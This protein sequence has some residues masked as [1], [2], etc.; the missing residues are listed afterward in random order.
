MQGSQTF[1]ILLLL[2][3]C[4]F[5]V[6]CTASPTLPPTPVRIEV[7][8]PVEVTRLVT[9][10]VTQQIVTAATP[11]PAVPCAALQPGDGAIVTIGAIIPLSSPGAILAGFAMQAAL[12]IAVSELN[13]QGGIEGTPV[14]LVTYDSAGSPERSAQFA[15]RLILLDCAVAIVGLYHNGEALAVADVAHRYAIPVIVTAATS[16]DITQ[17]GYAEIFRIAP[18]N[19]MLAQMPAL[20]LKDV[21]DYNRD[22]VIVATL[23]ADA[24][25]NSST[26][27]E[28]TQATMIQA[29]IETEVLRVDLPSTNFSSVVARLV[30]REHLPD[31]IFIYI[32]GEPALL[33]QA[34]L[35]AAGIGPQ[36]STLFVQNHAGLNSTQFWSEVPGGTGTIVTRIGA[37]PSTLTPRGQDFVTKYDQYVGQWP[38][39]YAFASYDAIWL[40]AEALT[41]APTWAGSDLVPMLEATDQET[42]SGRVTF[43]FSSAGT[44]T[45]DLP[46]SLW[47]QWDEGQILYLQYTLPDQPADAMPIIWP[48][49][50]RTADLQP[51]TTPANP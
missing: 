1:R 15:E 33:L 50:F 23:I 25:H 46:P 3:A 29:G 37:W 8:V 40:L 49:R 4:L 9:Q 20:W 10:Q 16:D 30:A 38:E 44:D 39:S 2:M 26:L 42:T 41:G 47:H 18:S 22:G 5:L 43:R 7:E 17:R 13:E 34:E 12:N 21:G 14:R 36:R 24:S 6:G 32:K 35:L 19:S 28:T 27:V 45:G 48:P 51:A 11:T 31:A